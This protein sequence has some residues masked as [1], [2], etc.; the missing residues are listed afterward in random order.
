M[1]VL[2]GLGP[3]NIFNDRHGSARAVPERRRC[4]VVQTGAL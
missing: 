2:Q 1:R 3:L 4:G